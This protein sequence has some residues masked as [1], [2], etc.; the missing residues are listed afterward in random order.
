MFIG[1]EAELTEL[2]SKFS[3]Q[4]ARLVVIKGR[5]RVGKTRLAKELGSRIKGSK[6]HYFTASPPNK[7]ISDEQERLQFAQY[8]VHEF[9]LQYIPPYQNW[10]SLLYFIA[11]QCRAKKTILIL[12]E[13]NWMGSKCSTFLNE[14]HQVWETNFTNKR[15]FMLI[16]AGSLST[17]LEENIL[18]HTGFVGRVS[19]DLTLHD[20]PLRHCVKFWGDKTKQSSNHEIIKQLCITG[21]IPRYIEELDFSATAEQNIT[22]LCLKPSGM[23]FDEFD[24]MF[25]DIFSTWNDLYLSILRGIADS[26]SKL[27]VFELAKII[28]RPL[29]GT[30]TQCIDNLARAGFISRDFS[31]DPKSGQVLKKPKLRISDCYTAFYFRAIDKNKDQVRNGAITLNNLASLAGLQF[32][33]LILNNRKT[34]WGILKLTAANILFDNPFY[35]STTTRRNG[36]QINYLIQ[37]RNNIF[38]ICEIKFHSKEIEMQIT[39]DMEKKITALKIPKQAS[40]RTVLIHVNGVSSRVVDSAYFDHIIDVALLMAD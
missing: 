40:Y 7:A 6:T 11:D 37:T 31:W 2:E 22:N 28:G 5:R 29:N 39:Q 32:E 1:R 19:L 8:V 13:I 16:L 38:Y 33:N 36:C 4:K 3:L 15:G 18:H 10:S 26:S 12:D 17:W 9:K 27:G 23:L 21:G 14:L 34:V 30:F 24:D 20:L 25:S 35:Q